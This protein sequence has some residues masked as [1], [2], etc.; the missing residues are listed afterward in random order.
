M[1]FVHVKKSKRIGVIFST[2]NEKF[3]FHN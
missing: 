3:P 1:K 2:F